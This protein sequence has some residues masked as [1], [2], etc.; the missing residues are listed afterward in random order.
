MNVLYLSYTGLLE[1]LG[2]SQVLNYL[3][4]L[5]REH[6][7]S[8]VTFEK[9]RD[10]ADQDTV[11]AMR[12]SCA[13]A[14]IRWLPRRYHGRPRFLA[15]LWDLL[16]FFWT[17]WRE[18][19]AIR[20]DLVHARSYIPAF[21]ALALKRLTGRP[22]IFDMRAFWVEELI[23]AGRLRRGSALHR[24]LV[25]GER[26]CLREAAAV[27]SLTHAA[28]AHM[29]SEAPDLAN[30]R[31]AVIP[32][33]TDLDRFQPRGDRDG[34][35][36]TVGCV[37]TV[38][39]G[40]F[41][42]D[43]LMAF[44]SRMREDFPQARA[45]IVSRDDP[46]RI[47][48]MSDNQIEVTVCAPA[49]VPAALAALSATVMFFDQAASEIARCPTRMGEALACGVPVVG[50]PWVGDVG[51]IVRRYQ[52]GVLIEENTDQAMAAAVAELQA[53]LKDPELAARCRKAAEDWFSLEKGAAAYA[54]LYAEAV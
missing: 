28:V 36:P 1:P 39:S 5:A 45:R 50:N 25:A 46:A 20:A 7:I 49:D 11:E 23:T 15:T 35:A 21:T 29:K 27:V 34:A 19:R 2:Q 10:L 16:V 24:L 6:R 14:G 37:G 43:W 18:A 22:F 47:A 40:W 32:T 8:I 12:R 31:F 33:C 42:F 52:V 54:R 17:A 38:L 51:E 13:A 44:F 4:I 48:A 53:L 9:P 3:R 30:V 26:R 41:R